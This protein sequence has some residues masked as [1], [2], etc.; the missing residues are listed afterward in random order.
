MSKNI[1]P[2]GWD[3]K[4]VRRVIEHYENQS[5]D[6]AVAE[7]EAPYE[8]PTETMMAVPIDLVPRV[9]ELIARRQSA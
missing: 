3:E 6:E 4:R 1:Y 5:D 7:D 8:T 2:A 9:R